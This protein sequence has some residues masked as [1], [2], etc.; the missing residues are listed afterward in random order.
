MKISEE[1]KL[2]L[3]AI[4]QK[5]LH[6]ERIKKMMDIPMHRGSNCYFHSFKVA[7]LAIKNALRHKKVLLE[8]VLISAILHDYY[9]YDWRTD[10]QKLKG[11]G[12]N[13]PY[14]AAKQAEEDFDVDT[15]VKKAIETHMWPINFSDFPKTKE[16]RIVSIADKMIAIREASTSIAYKKKRRDKY[17]KYID[18]LF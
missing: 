2:E 10:R 8:A 16:A 18:K 15:I 6:D 14:I 4:Y 7:K 12:H 5:F 13:H 9:L 3:E 11:H 1:R 17:L